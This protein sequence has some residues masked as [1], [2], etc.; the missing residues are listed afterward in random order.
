MQ[1]FTVGFPLG[2]APDKRPEPRTP[3]ENSAKA[4]GDPDTVRELI[5]KELDLGHMLASFD[6]P[7][8]PNILFSPLHLVPKAGDNDK[9]RLIHNLA[10]PYDQEIFNKCIPPEE[11]SVNYHCIDQLIQLSLDFG[12][13]IWGA[14]WIFLMRAAIYQYNLRIWDY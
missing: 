14:E 5:E 13:N 9:S 8:L 10:F 11:K 6:E 7:P 4:Q 1:G 3:C 2:L 12:P